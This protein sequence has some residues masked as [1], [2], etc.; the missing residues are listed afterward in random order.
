MREEIFAVVGRDTLPC[1]AHKP[2]LPYCTAFLAEVIEIALRRENG[3][4]LGST[5]RECSWMES[6]EKDY[7]RDAGE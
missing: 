5:M 6:D 4:N 7:N 3:E 2:Q 1:M